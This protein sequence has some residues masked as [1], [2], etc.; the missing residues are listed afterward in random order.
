V[1]FGNPSD[2]GREFD[3]SA[4]LTRDPLPSGFDPGEIL[5]R[6]TVTVSQIVRLVKTT[7]IAVWVSGVAGTPVLGDSVYPAFDESPIEVKSKR[8]PKRCPDGIVVEPVYPER[9][10]GWMT[11]K[12]LGI[13]EA[14]RTVRFTHA[15]HSP[16]AR[17]ASHYTAH[18][19]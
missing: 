6:N 13:H 1:R 18:L 2:G 17:L 9:T 12:S 10:K 4:I 5:T 7:G 16:L 8:L 3:L 19:G 14:C 11:G 15:S